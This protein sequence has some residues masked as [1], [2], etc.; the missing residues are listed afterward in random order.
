MLERLQVIGVCRAR[1]GSP[2]ARLRSFR[3][4][5]SRSKFRHARNDHEVGVIHTPE[6]IRQHAQQV[7]QQASV[8]KLMPLNN[9]TQ[10]TELERSEIKRWYES[11]AQPN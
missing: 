3:G 7:Y 11:G 2:G 5:Y 10:I 4:T 1:P 8:L 9:A 6:L